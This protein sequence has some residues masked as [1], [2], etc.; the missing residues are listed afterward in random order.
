VGPLRPSALGVPPGAQL[1][2]ACLEAL[3]AARQQS[4]KGRILYLGSPEDEEGLR[5]V[6]EAVEDDETRRAL[7]RSCLGLV[8]SSSDWLVAS[9]PSPETV[10]RVWGP[11]VVEI[12]MERLLAACRAAAGEG[13]AD[14]GVEAALRSLVRD[15]GLDAVT[16][17][18]FDLIGARQVTACLAL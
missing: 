3:A 7:G 9:S 6:V 14:G 2:P 18:C 10:R 8:G 15:E 11:Q 17:R 5:A 16:V 13:A 1:T 4:G 12:A